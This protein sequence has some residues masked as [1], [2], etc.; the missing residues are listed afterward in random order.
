M[1]CMQLFS[2]FTATGINIHDQ[3]S[4][5]CINTPTLHWLH[6]A[7]SGKCKAVGAEVDPDMVAA[8]GFASV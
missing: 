8:A 5:G 1:Q 4:V 2:V 7:L 6:L 3:I